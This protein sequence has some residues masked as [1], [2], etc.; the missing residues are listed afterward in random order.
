M[1]N[2]ESALPLWS[3]YRVRS[4]QKELFFFFFSNVNSWG[5][6]QYY[7]LARFRDLSGVLWSTTLYHV[8]ANGFSQN[9]SKPEVSLVFL[10]LPDGSPDFS[11]SVQTFSVGCSPFGLLLSHLG[12]WNRAIK[13]HKVQSCLL[14]EIFPHSFHV[15]SSRRGSIF[16]PPL[17]SIRSVGGFRISTGRGLKVANW[18]RDKL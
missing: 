5:N 1:C 17:Y 4:N 14:S 12:K 11:V 2:L 15:L 6:N 3:L 18:K 13:S 16:L 7:Y 9:Q 10:I 8:P